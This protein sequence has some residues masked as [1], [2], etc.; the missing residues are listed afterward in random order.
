VPKSL[1]NQLAVEIDGE[2]LYPLGEG[3][4][5]QSWPY[6]MRCLEFSEKAMS[7]IRSWFYQLQFPSPDSTQNLALTNLVKI[8]AVAILFSDMRSLD[9][10]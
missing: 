2:Q 5:P 7:W 10:L 3:L 4:F 9:D 1:A 6:P 8:L